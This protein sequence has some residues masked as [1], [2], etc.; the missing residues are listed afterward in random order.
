M[1]K[2]GNSDLMVGDQ[3][4]FEPAPVQ[5][6]G[7]GG[8]GI[9]E[10]LLPR[11]NQ[12]YRPPVA[13]VD[14]LIIVM[15]IKEPE[16]DWQLVSRMLVLAEKENLKINICLNKADLAGSG[17][18]VSLQ[19]KLNPFPYPFF[20]TSA[21]EGTGIEHLR[22]ILDGNCSVFA[23]P[24]GV[25]KSSLLNAVQPGLAL[26]TGVVSDKIKRGKHTTRQAELLALKS[27]GSVVDTPGFTR[28]E[29]SDILPTELPSFFPEFDSLLG[30]CT[31]RDCAHLSEPGC[32]VLKEVGISVN[33]MRYEH[34]K[35]FSEE[36][37]KQEG[38]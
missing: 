24:S 15:S 17:Q 22:G 25:G 8:D 9:I 34:Y 4:V 6:G 35:Y 7:D 1:L 31:F 18:I 16:C 38:Y 26:Q 20:F 37:S 19:E 23:G 28:L 30:Q 10:K 29:F 5:P 14:Q 36:L 21:R 27:G 11:A 32:A 33:P 12:L 2:R 13:N 3:V